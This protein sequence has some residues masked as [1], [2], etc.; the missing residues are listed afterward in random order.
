MAEKFDI[1][2]PKNKNIIIVTFLAI[3][4]IV[5]FYYFLLAPKDAVIKQLETDVSTKKTELARLIQLQSRVV[6]LQAD[7][8]N[9]NAR[10]EAAK[11]LLPTSQELPK[12]LRDISYASQS[13]DLSLEN[14]RPGSLTSK[15]DYFE[16]PLDLTLKG[17]FHSLGYFLSNLSLLPRI[18]NVND[19]TITGNQSLTKDKKNYTIGVT[20]QLSSYIYNVKK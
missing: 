13:A 6:E 2:D 3:F 18:I 12:L 20:L 8:E 10:I 4:L 1:N 9:N 11:K 14:F 7:I 5:G 19:F 16:F 15:G 17:N